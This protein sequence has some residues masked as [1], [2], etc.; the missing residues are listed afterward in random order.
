MP[1]LAQVVD[2]FKP[3]S[4]RDRYRVR[5][6]V[7]R[8]Q[9]NNMVRIVNRNGREVIE[10]TTHGK[11]RVL[12]YD[13]ENMQLETKKKW[14][15]KWRIVM[16][17]IPQTKKKA[18]D[19]VSFKIKEIGMYP[20][21][22]SVFVFPHTCKD[23][24]DFV[25]RNEPEETA[26]ELVLALKK[27]GIPPSKKGY[28]EKQLRDVTTP[29]IVQRARTPHDLDIELMESLAKKETRQLKSIEEAIKKLEG[30]KSSPKQQK[31]LELLKKKE[32]ESEWKK[33]A[34]KPSP[35]ISGA[36]RASSLRKSLEIMQEKYPL[37]EQ[38]QVYS[39]GRQ[40]LVLEQPKPQ[41][42]VRIFEPTIIGT[43]I[44]KSLAQQIIDSRKTNIYTPQKIFMGVKPKLSFFTDLKRETLLKQKIMTELKS[45]TKSITDLANKL[46]TETKTE[47]KLRSL[48]ELKS[49]TKLDTRLKTRTDLKT[50]ITAPPTEIR[51]WFFP[52][53]QADISFKKKSKFKKYKFPKFKMQKAS[54]QFF[55][56]SDPIS[57]LKTELRTM[58]RARQPKITKK[59]IKEYRKLLTGEKWVMPTL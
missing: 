1:N 15:G 48:T 37:V 40:Q 19:A 24:I 5:Q 38:E 7:K 52:K 39:S 54:E 57:L 9:K 42:T 30:R 10:L 25:I 4:S 50:D 34:L 23:E 41:E 3:R 47:R 51:K 22:K 31:K 56:Y 14:D 58:K 13:I 33:E 20:I 45:K 2:L 36:V 44:S 6:A 8:L 27:K 28:T 18:R 53:I 17:D 49:L 29:S 46:K 35:T 43:G 16:F 21:Q 12:D 26:K 55:P 11:K 32:M 59:S